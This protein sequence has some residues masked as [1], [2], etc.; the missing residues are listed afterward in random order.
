MREISKRYYSAAETL[1]A[2]IKKKLLEVTTWYRNRSKEDGESHGIDIEGDRGKWKRYR[3][4]QSD[5]KKKGVKRQRSGHGEREQETKICDL[6][7][8]Y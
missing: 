5:I 8:A 2:R 4:Y 1:D 6:H 7:P 3:K